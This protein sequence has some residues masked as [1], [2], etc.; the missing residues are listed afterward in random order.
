MNIGDVKQ[1]RF[2]Q[3]DREVMPALRGF[4]LP[5]DEY[6]SAG[7][8]IPDEAKL[9]QFRFFREAGRA[10]FIGPETVILFDFWML[11]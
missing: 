5:S 9:A 6:F 4:S 7:D 10:G 1:I 8:R 2:P 3:S 11:R